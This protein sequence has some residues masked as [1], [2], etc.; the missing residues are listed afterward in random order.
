MKIVFITSYL[1]SFLKSNLS[2]NKKSFVG[3]FEAGSRNYKP[4]LINNIFRKI[5]KSKLKKLAIRENLDYFFLQKKNQKDAVEFL[6]RIKPD[7]I[8]VYSMS[9]LLCKEIIEIPKLGIFNLHPS[10]LPKYRGPN[11]LFWTYY[12]Q[13]KIAGM[14]LHYI[15]Q[16][17]DTGDIIFQ[18]EVKVKL[19]LEI[20]ILQEKFNAIGS[21]LI[22]RL[23]ET[24]KQ[25][26]SLPRKS[27]NNYG[28]SKRA[29]NLSNKE[30]EKIIDWENFEV[31]R[32]WHIIKGLGSEL[33]YI[34]QP[35]GIFYGQKWILEDYIKLDSK[36]KNNKQFG[37]IYFI[38]NQYILYCKDGIIKLKVR[39]K[40]NYLLKSLIKLILK[41]IK[42]VFKYF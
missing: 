4:N 13:D 15:D 41:F 39:F 34:S 17:E 23:I 14:T 24:L 21:E 12:N 28:N 27:Q 19:G 29:N 36:N 25:G 3:I 35:K 18:K 20:E 30:L 10:L 33:P 6:L 22:F 31:E 8:I 42:S 16:G 40:F 5:F 7:L 38:N 37:K 1:N 32:V 26:E 2:I 11:P 9:H